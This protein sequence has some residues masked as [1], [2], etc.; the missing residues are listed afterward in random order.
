MQEKYIITNTTVK[1]PRIDPITKQDGR[2]L[3][4]KNGYMVSYRD[5]RDQVTVLRASEFRQVTEVPDNVW[6]L[7]S[8]GLV[9]VRKAKDVAEELKGHTFKRERRGAKAPVAADAPVAAPTE[10]KAEKATRGKRQARV[11]EMGQDGHRGA[12]SPEDG[13]IHPDGE[14]NF[15]VQAPSAETRR[16]SRE[17][18]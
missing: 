10:E 17:R 12:D 7:E 1:Q 3:T 4:E 14:P 5:K 13:A 2:T 9:S 6:G 18:S 16:R 8:E 15:V 11:V